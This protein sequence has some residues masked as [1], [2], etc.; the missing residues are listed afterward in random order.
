MADKYF[1]KSLMKSTHSL[2]DRMEQFQ[3]LQPLSA[4]SR[5]KGAPEKWQLPPTELSL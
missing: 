4:L 2:D 3:P 1:G 5:D